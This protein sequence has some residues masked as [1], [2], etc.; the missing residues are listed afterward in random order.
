MYGLMLIVLILVTVV[1]GT[2]RVMEQRLR[3]RWER[4]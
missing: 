1:N 2:V 3:R 4:A